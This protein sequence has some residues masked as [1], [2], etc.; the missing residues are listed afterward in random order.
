[1]PRK[2]NGAPHAEPSKA[3]AKQAPPPATPKGRAGAKP[4]RVS[5]VNSPLTVAELAEK[6]VEYLEKYD[7]VTVLFGDI[8][9]YLTEHHRASGMGIVSAIKLLEDKGRIECRT[10]NK[11]RVVTLV[12]QD[13][14]DDDETEKDPER[15]DDIETGKTENHK[16]VLSAEE[17][18][19]E[20]KKREAEDVLIEQLLGELKTA[21]STVKAKQKEIDELL[22]K[23]R[24]RAKWCRDGFR[25]MQVR[26]EERREYDKRPGAKP[27]RLMMITYRLDTDEPIRWREPTHKELQE[28]M[29]DRAAPTPKNTQVRE[30]SP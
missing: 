15:A 3:G 10:S 17:I 12:E 5:P 21:K 11:G 2:S 22:K 23:G 9:R 16:H 20:R 13:E 30:A 27:N 28:H 26:V 24:E 14:D 8:E 7:G 19:S 25:M 4:G 6:A 29:F 1:M 18:E